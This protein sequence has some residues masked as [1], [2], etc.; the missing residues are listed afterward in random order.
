MGNTASKTKDRKNHDHDNIPSDSP[1]GLMLEYWKD[2][3]RTK[4]K[5]KQQMIK[6]C[7][8]VWTKEPSSPPQ[9]AATTDPSPKPKKGG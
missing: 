5:K 9:A 3:G 8:F 1:L 6:Y 2:N 4:H 7:C